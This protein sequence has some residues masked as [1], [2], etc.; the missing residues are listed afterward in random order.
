[1]ISAPEPWLPHQYNEWVDTQE[2]YSL[3]VLR[4]YYEDAAARSSDMANY[5]KY[6]AQVAGSHR[7]IPDTP[8]PV[9]K[10]SWVSDPMMIILCRKDR[11]RPLLI[12]QGPQQ[13][14]PLPPQQQPESQQEEV[15]WGMIGDLVEEPGELEAADEHGGPSDV[16]HA[17]V[18]GPHGHGGFD[19]HDGLGSHYGGPGQY[20]GARHGDFRY[21]GWP[22]HGRRG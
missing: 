17:S 10:E 5:Q 21:G 20:L 15:D 12:V 9:P 4:G 22:E 18:S 13:H 6:V 11:R 1:M 19:S 7:G 8:P 3:A 14:D 2:Q 16:S